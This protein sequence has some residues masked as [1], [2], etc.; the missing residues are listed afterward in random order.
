KFFSSLF[1]LL[2]AKAM[3]SNA[4]SSTSATSN[5][6][7]IEQIKTW[8]EDLKRHFDEITERID[9]VDEGITERI[10]RV[11]HEIKKVRIQSKLMWHSAPSMSFFSGTSSIIRSIIISY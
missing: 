5:L 11:S 2:I 1:I 3:S 6:L 8:T 7:K 4:S 9:K 10:D